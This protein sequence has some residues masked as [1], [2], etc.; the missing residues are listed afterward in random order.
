MFYTFCPLFCSNL[1]CSFYYLSSLCHHITCV[2]ITTCII[3]TSTGTTVLINSSEC[4]IR[5][6]SFSIRF[7][8]FLVM[9]D[10]QST[11]IKETIYHFVHD[12]L[13]FV[14]FSI[15]CFSHIPPRKVRVLMYPSHSTLLK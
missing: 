12:F 6:I 13:W 1:F 4:F 8:F 15:L 9:S 5:L 3:R 2:R 7:S 14:F 11:I 10:L